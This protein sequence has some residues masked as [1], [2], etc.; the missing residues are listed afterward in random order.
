MA[1]GPTPQDLV[2]SAPPDVLQLDLWGPGG[3]GGEFESWFWFYGLLSGS[4][5]LDQ[6]RFFATIVQPGRTNT[7][8]GGAPQHQSFSQK[9]PSGR[10][11][12]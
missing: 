8:G 2:L 10:G 12:D 5:V 4:S 11:S 7:G 1:E 9:T 3:S 6:L